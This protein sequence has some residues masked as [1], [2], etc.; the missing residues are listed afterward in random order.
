MNTLGPI[1]L[2]LLLLGCERTAQS[3]S[4]ASA[5]SNI[6]SPSPTPR[7][8]I[9]DKIYP[10]TEAAYKNQHVTLIERKEIEKWAAP[11]SPS[12]DGRFRHNPLRQN[13]L[14]QSEQRLVRWMRSPFESGGLLVFV[15]RPIEETANV[16]SPWVALNSNVIIDTVECSVHAY[17]TA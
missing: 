5:V 11:A 15:A 3:S 13:D 14:L 10:A 8:W 2:A 7:C 12:Q 17:S 1:C 4:Q 6:A 16:Y 9:Y